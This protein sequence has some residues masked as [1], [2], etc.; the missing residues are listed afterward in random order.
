M[1]MLKRIFRVSAGWMAV[2]VETISR[3]GTELFLIPV[4]NEDH[5][6][7]S[8]TP[9]V[10][11]VSTLELHHCKVCYLAARGSTRFGGIC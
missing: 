8:L 5:L 3:P 6:R 7:E 4:Y 2:S 1:S 11:P 10:S 9:S